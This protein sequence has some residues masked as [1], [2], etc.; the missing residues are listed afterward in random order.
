MPRLGLPAYQW[1]SEG[2][3]GVANSPGVSFNPDNR[4][5]FGSATSFPQ[6]I[7][8]GAAF[9]DALVLAVATTVSTEARAFSN[10]ERAG[11]DFWTP[12]INP[13]R[14]PR[15]GRGQE[16]PGE[17]P[18]HLSSYV[19]ALIAGLQG[20][21]DSAGSVDGKYKKIIST[22]KHFAGYDVESWDGN[23]RYQFDASIS[24]QDMV[25]YY[26]PSFQACARDARVGAFMCSYNAVNGVPTCAD[27]WLL[28]DVLR[29]HW[30]WTS[31]KEGFWVTSDC[32]AVQN[33]FLPHRWADSREGAAA[34]S[35]KAGTDLNCGRYYSRHLGAAYDQRLIN[36]THLDTA[37]TRLYAS[38]VSLGYFDPAADQPY[39]AL[40]WAD[41]NTPAAQQL[42]YQAAV[43]GTVL[44]KNVNGTLPLSLAGKKVAVL[45]EWAAATTQMQGSY[46]GVPPYLH[47]P[48][49]AV[50]QLVGNDSTFYSSSGFGDPT[51]DG[52][53]SVW[54]AANAADI[55]LYFGGVDD[56]IE[57]EG[58]DRI[59][60]AWTGY[61]LDLIGDLA[62]TGKPLVVVQMGGGQLDSS[63]LVNNP[64]VSALLWGGYPGQDGGVAILDVIT[65]AQA[66]AGR[67]PLT[68]YPA[69]YIQNVS[70]TDMALRPDHAS[71]FP[72]RTYR[73]YDGQAV[74]PFGSGLHYT[75]FAADMALPGAASRFDIASL[76][77]NCS[78]VAYMDLCPFTSLPVTIDNTG[79]P[80]S[81]YV[82]LLFL[83]GEFGPQPY[84]IKTLVAYDRAHNITGGS[85]GQV[86]L[87]LTLG[88]LSRVDEN[89]NRV[90]YPGS[91][92]LMLDLEPGLAT[93]NFTLTG[94]QAVL[95]KWPAAPAGRRGTG[96][97]EVGQDYYVGGVGTINDAGG[98]TLLST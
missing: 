50:Q 34:A 81:D 94:E 89:G 33:V 31:D 45:G 11:L 72:G 80:T 19:K 91:Y 22:C 90:L 30:N 52:W 2:L 26:L 76:T 5:D 58:N 7:T 48:L 71:S 24:T 70:M 3:H 98:Q 65:G 73:W 97:A 68:Q 66:P 16:T 85:S 17:D 62:L 44:L 53:D 69:D 86:T 37:L 21:D 55:L 79:S 46:Y 61:A 63:P 13:F 32:D 92:S 10:A 59:S 39:R 40:G 84:P 49:Y 82:A 51:T 87:D 95:D 35:L 14:D 20:T 96:T 42:A 88:S 47:S 38:L 8:I 54:E 77:S 6:P 27:D 67:L 1:W 78:G 12:N 18:F 9:D 60:L 4:S 64:G 75:T 57:S 29:D 74:F 41:V 56:S 93:V 23:Y 28:N 15:W 43:A 83:S 25:E 36:D